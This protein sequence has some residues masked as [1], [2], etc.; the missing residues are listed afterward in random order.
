MQNKTKTTT[1]IPS[2][3]SRNLLN[4]KLLPNRRTIQLHISILISHNSIRNMLALLIHLCHLPQNKPL[5]RKERVLWVH[6]DLLFCN[7]THQH[8]T[9]YCIR[10]H[11]WCRYLPL[12]VRHYR[13]LPTFHRRHRRIR[14]PQISDSG[15]DWWSDP[16]MWVSDYWSN[17]LVGQIGGHWLGLLLVQA[18]DCKV[19]SGFRVAA[20]FILNFWGFFFHV[21][22]IIFLGL[23]V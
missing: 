4:C 13:R 11:R 6:N 17:W 15:G 19:F 18:S 7:L 20:V 9:I 21:D 12:G 10:H 22:F 23:W 8:I 2:Y 5:H 1:P 3:L 16:F 14:C